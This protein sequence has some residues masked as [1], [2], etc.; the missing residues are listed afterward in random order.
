MSINIWGLS[1]ITPFA[2]KTSFED[3]KIEMQTNGTQNKP[4]HEQQP[5]GERQADKMDKIK[6]KGTEMKIMS[7]QTRTRDVRSPTR[8]E[9]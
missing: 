4:K 3:E 1:Y 8:Y 6:A 9:S 5:E 7:S 2:D